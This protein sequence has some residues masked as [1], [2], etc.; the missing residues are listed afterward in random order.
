MRKLS[1]QEIERIVNLLREG[2]PLPED[3]RTLLSDS[4]RQYNVLHPSKEQDL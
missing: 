3:Y 2:K 4:N 1:E